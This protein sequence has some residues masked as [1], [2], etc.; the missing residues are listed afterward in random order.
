M[1][2]AIN[3]LMASVIIALTIALITISI[4]MLQGR[5]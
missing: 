2:K 5:G 3:L 4:I 1:E